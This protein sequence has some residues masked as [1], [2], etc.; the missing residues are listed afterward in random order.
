MNDFFIVYKDSVILYTVLEFP[1]HLVWT[2][3]HFYVRMGSNVLCFCGLLVL[4]FSYNLRF[5]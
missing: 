2:E 4:N 3:M 1:I 5:V